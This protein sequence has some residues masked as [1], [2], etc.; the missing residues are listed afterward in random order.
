[1]HAVCPNDPSHNRFVTTAHVLQDWVVDE[2]GNFIREV[3]TL[4]TAHGPDA[5]NIWT[6]EICGIEA[7]VR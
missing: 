2:L 3:S 1:M 5:G 6:C 7:E 4:E